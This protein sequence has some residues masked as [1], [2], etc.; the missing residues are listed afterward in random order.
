M[1]LNWECPFS[2][3]LA[4]H[5]DACVRC[6][7]RRSHSLFHLFTRLAMNVNFLQHIVLYAM[8]ALTLVAVACGDS[9]P[10]SETSVPMTDA[11]GIDGLD[12]GAFD[13]LPWAPGS[14]DRTTGT[15]RL[16]VPRPDLVFTVDGVRLTSGEAAAGWAAFKPIPGG[17]V[18]TAELP[19]LAD[20]VN[21]VL[22]AALLHD[23]RVTSLHPHF[24]REVPRLL[25]L[26]LAAIGETDSLASAMGAVLQTLQ[27]V[28][29]QPREVPPP[30]DP[31]LVTFYPAPVDS[32]LRVRGRMRDGAYEITLPRSATL[33]GFDLGAASGIASRVT[34]AGGPSSAVVRGRLAVLEEELQPVLKALRA[35]GIEIASID[36]AAM[37]E[38]P[39][40]VYVHL[41]GR[42]SATA[43][44][45]AIRDALDVIGR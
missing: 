16:P 22:S 2:L 3:W 7:S 27:D 10:E 39:N 20:E 24:T 34:F 32:I 9:P 13:S 28:R 35:A 11:R 38:E 43:L 14:L 30:I 18:L 1:A 40:Y 21:P 17:A 29:G 33:E 6:R 23:L 45:Q 5:H 8:T 12:P 41:W 15:Y 19:L 26:H 36:D 31:G 37:G 25:F 4:R 42:G 44:A